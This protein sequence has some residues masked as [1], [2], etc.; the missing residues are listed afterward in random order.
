MLRKEMMVRCLCC[1][2][3]T[4]WKLNTPTLN[5]T[6]DEMIKVA[7][8][9]YEKNKSLFDDTMEIDLNQVAQSLFENKINSATIIPFL[10]YAVVHFPEKK[11]ETCNII[12][13]IEKGWELCFLKVLVSNM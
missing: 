2:F 4:A 1:D 10:I 8:D 12:F 11:R 3:F 7:K 6:L 9:L 5:F 13:S